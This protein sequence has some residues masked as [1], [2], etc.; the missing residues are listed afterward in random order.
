MLL[1][2]IWRTRRL[3]ANVDISAWTHLDELVSSG[4]IWSAIASAVA[5]ANPLPAPKCGLTSLQSECRS[6]TTDAKHSIWATER[7]AISQFIG[8]CIEHAV[9]TCSMI[10]VSKGEQGG[11]IV[12]IRWRGLTFLEFPKVC[13]AR[14][15]AALIRAIGVVWARVW[16]RFGGRFRN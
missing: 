16:R 8:Q 1:C 3:I 15:V 13:Q 10:S 4:T 6:R 2:V 7:N 12:P 11:K 5:S 9:Q 14:R